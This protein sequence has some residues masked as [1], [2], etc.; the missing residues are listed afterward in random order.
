[1]K[2]S[3]FVLIALGIALIDIII[4]FVILKDIGT[5]SANYLFW[6]LLTLGVIIFGALYTRKWGKKQ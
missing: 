5:F 3:T 2:G 4:P 1:M 6:S